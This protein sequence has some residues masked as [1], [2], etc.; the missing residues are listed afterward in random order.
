MRHATRLCPNPDCFTRLVAA[1]WL[2][3]KSFAAFGSL[4]SWC[5]MTD[6]VLNAPDKGVKV[7]RN[8]LTCNVKKSAFLD[9]SSSILEVWCRERPLDPALLKRES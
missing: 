1:E 9:S 7:Q 6:S 4:G 3:A 8:E 2:S 5:L